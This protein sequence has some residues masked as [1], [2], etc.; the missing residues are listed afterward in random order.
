MSTV[1]KAIRACDAVWDDDAAWAA[2]CAREATADGQFYYAVRT[3]GVY[4]RPSCSSRRPRRENVS[5]HGTP[6]AAEAAGF[7]PCKRCR[8]DGPTREE[9][10][11]AAI[12]NACRVIETS[13]TL[14]DLDT[15]ATAAGMSRFHFHR[16]FKQVTGVTPRAFAAAERKTRMRDELVKQSSV[17]AAIYGAGFNSNGRFYAASHQALGMKPGVFREGGAGERIRFAVGESALGAILVAATVRGLC[18]ISLGDDPEVLIHEL[19]DRFHRAE[20]VGGDAAF[21][22]TV[23]QVVAFVDEPRRGLD[24]PLDIR[25][26]AFQERVWQ[27]LSRIAPGQT[28]SYA[29]IATTIG[30]PRAVRAVA[31]ACAA[32]TLAVAIPCH[33]VVRNDG[34]L[35]GY[36]WGVER[37]RA[38]LAREE[39]A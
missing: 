28:V 30:Q 12:A 1:M 26:T 39:G 6:V 27:A 21:E 22:A 34:A 18:A 17:T 13:Q 20:L 25:G 5:F 37:K 29:D 11:A 31:R 14:P 9:R 36:R 32:N 35:S 7:R 2:V 19:E 33:R 38:L 24:L 4:C 16:I 15:L 10:H 3:T 8:P 23:A